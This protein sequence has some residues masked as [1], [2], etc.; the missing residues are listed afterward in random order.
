MHTVTAILHNCSQCCYCRNERTTEL[1]GLLCELDEGLLSANLLLSLLVCLLCTKRLSHHRCQALRLL[2][3]ADL[4]LNTR[5]LLRLLVEQTALCATDSRR[6]A[7]AGPAVV[8]AALRALL[9]VEGADSVTSTGDAAVVAGAFLATGLAHEAHC[10]LADAKLQLARSLDEALALPTT[11]LPSEHGALHMARVAHER[12]L[13][14][15]SGLVWQSHVVPHA[16]ASVVA[17]AGQVVMQIN[18]AAVLALLPHV[19]V[20]ALAR[21]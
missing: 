13:A 4:S 14:L 8:A 2:G 9:M 18:R 11:D 5:A 17:T 6:A 20:L 21:S 10:T 12:L 7:V 16:G 19:C 15:A 1:L 3:A